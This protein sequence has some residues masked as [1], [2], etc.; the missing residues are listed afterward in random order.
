ME[1][2]W[3]EFYKGYFISNLGRVRRNYGPRL[4][5]EGFCYLKPF[6][7]KSRKAMS[8]VIKPKHDPFKAYQVHNLVSKYFMTPPKRGEFI[9][10]K[11]GDARNNRVDNLEYYR[12]SRKPYISNDGY[13]RIHDFDHPN[14]DS[15]GWLAENRYVMSK[16][17]NRPLRPSENVHHINGIR[18][19]NRLENLE[20][21]VSH[22]PRGQR[23]I[24]LV[25]W[26]KE[27]L[28]IYGDEVG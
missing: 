8:F 25:E 26:A 12:R 7:T 15:E 17:L 5:N 27:I 11:D 22:Q 10:H 18:S 28:D 24:D 2:T 16:S 19:D 3:K 1:E 4:N 14:S 6:L 13:R 21:W 23:P 9:R 20:L